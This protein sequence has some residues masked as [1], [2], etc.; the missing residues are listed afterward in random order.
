[1]LA[2]LARAS[3]RQVCARDAG[4]DGGARSGASAAGFQFKTRRLRARRA[5]P[6]ATNPTQAQLPGRARRVPGGRTS[7]LPRGGS[8]KGAPPGRAAPACTPGYANGLLCWSLYQSFRPGEPFQLWWDDLS[9]RIRLVLIL[10]CD[11]F[12][13][14]PST[15]IFL[16]PFLC[17]LPFSPSDGW[18]LC[19][20]VLTPLTC[21]FLLDPSASFLH[22]HSSILLE[23]I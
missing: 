7:A 20:C 12:S 23:S 16:V 10:S 19:V 14:N 6:G 17:K 9:G 18:V 8:R 2:L 11:S 15:P 4:G 13:F 1:M 22:L 5:L 3:P 21:F